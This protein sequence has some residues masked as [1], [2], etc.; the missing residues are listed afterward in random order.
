LSVSSADGR[1]GEENELE[2]EPVRLGRSNQKIESLN[3][4]EQQN[5]LTTNTKTRNPNLYSQTRQPSNGI[6]SINNVSF[7]SDVSKTGSKTIGTESMGNSS[8][9]QLKIVVNQNRK[10]FKIFFHLFSYSIV[11]H[12]N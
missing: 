11:Y 9:N 7:I 10:L 6:R 4:R 2:N 5:S 1:E 8:T 3:D 12:L